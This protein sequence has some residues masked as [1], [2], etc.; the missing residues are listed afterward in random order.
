MTKLFKKSR[1]AK[2]R[3]HALHVP[4]LKH[5]WKHTLALYPSDK[6]RK[7]IFSITAKDDKSVS[8]VKLALILLGGIFIAVLV[9]ALVKRIREKL[10]AKKRNSA[11]CC[12]DDRL[13]AQIEE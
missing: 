2:K 13:C 7:P 4:T 1:G 11:H 9:A 10:R 6:S 12:C 8:V 3:P 5:S